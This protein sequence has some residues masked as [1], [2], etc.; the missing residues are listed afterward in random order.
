M[1]RQ[2]IDDFRRG[3]LEEKVYLERIR[4]QRDR[5]ETRDDDDDPMPAELRGKGNETAF[6]GISRR[7]LRKAGISDDYLAVRVSLSLTNIIERL[8]RVG[9]QYD[10]DVQNDMRNAMDDFFFDDIMSEDGV[11]IDPVVMDGIIN[12]VLAAARVRMQNDGRVR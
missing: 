1:I 10:R 11:D 9:W 6:W 4:R 7:E 3:R 2:T 8:R 12:E 5:L